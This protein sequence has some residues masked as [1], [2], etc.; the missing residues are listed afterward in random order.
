M[1]AKSQYE[2]EIEDPF[3]AEIRALERRMRML[4]RE[5]FAAKQKKEAEERSEKRS[6][7]D[8]IKMDEFKKNNPIP[9]QQRISHYTPPTIPTN[10]RFRR[11]KIILRETEYE[12]LLSATNK[13]VQ[14][15]IR[16]RKQ[17]GLVGDSADDVN[18]FL[19]RFKAFKD[20]FHA[21]SDRF[22]NK[23]WRHIK[24]DMKAMKEL[25]FGTDEEWKQT[26][27]EVAAFGKQERFLY[28]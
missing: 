23:Q 7:L 27:A 17:K 5:A 8:R 12:R 9:L 2:F 16:I 25:K 24:Q 26:C 18:L 1:S 22:T 10:I 3:D 6:L 21:R 15:F 13:A 4:R 11:S 20:T 28:A 19:D 14:K